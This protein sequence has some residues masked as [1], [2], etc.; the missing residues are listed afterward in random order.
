MIDIEN[1]DNCSLCQECIKYTQDFGIERGVR[2][3][4]NDHK[5]TFTVESTG[6]LDPDEIVHRAMKIL[7][8]KLSSFQ[9][10]IKKYSI[11]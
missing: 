10:H 5:F 2:I 11:I 6:A 4:E 7:H 1:A 8:D 9:E 3:T